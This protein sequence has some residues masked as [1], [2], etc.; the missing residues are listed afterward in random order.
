MMINRMSEH[1]SQ[2]QSIEEKAMTVRNVTQAVDRLV[3]HVNTTRYEDLPGPAVAAA[4]VFCLDTVGV[5]VAG[6]TA[7]YASEMRTAV[8]RWGSG[9]E[10]T[11]LGMGDRLPAGAAA[12]VNA[13]HAHNQE[14]DCVHE[15]AVVHPLTTIQ[16]AALAYAERARGVSGRELILALA[17]G[18]DVATSIGM[19]AKI[20]LAILSTCHRGR[21]RS[22][23]RGGQVGGPG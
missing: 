18:V 15:A 2:R 19:A 3:Q 21:I 5:C 14:F 22:H 6:T 10:A 11:V 12:M 4:K 17:L 13:F 8:G 1:S 20:G 7:R 9:E 16:S 23:C